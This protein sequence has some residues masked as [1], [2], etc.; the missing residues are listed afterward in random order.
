M[1]QL[2][3]CPV[4]LNTCTSNTEKKQGSEFTPY[5]TAASVPLALWRCM[6]P[7]L[8][9]SL[10]LEGAARSSELRLP[11]LLPPRGRSWL[12]EEL[13]PPEGVSGSE[14]SASNSWLS[15]KMSKGLA[16]GG[17]AGT[18][19]DTHQWKCEQRLK[20]PFRGG[21]PEVRLL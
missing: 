6:E 13:R 16:G 7:L 15:C 14:F 3:F 19:L 2:H 5:S 12:G 11:Q 20:G 4:A 9:R 21:E 10:G 1:K 18:V 8:C 17:A